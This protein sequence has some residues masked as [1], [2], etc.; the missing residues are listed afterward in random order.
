MKKPEDAD[1][2]EG[3]ER[4][5]GGGEPGKPGSAAT[6]LQ[7]SAERAL[8]ISTALLAVCFL[9]HILFLFLVEP[10]RYINISKEEAMTYSGI[11]LLIGFVFLPLAIYNFT[12]LESRTLLHIIALIFVFIFGSLTVQGLAGVGMHLIG[13]PH[14]K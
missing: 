11:P 6:A 3:W 5:G 8:F 4:A 7:R 2:G 9:S 14:G 13:M 10:L 1:T 12:K